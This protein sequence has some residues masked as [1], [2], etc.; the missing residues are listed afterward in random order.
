LSWHVVV[1]RSSKGSKL[2]VGFQEVI[3]YF[4]PRRVNES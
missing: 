1:G 2:N 4:R 3:A